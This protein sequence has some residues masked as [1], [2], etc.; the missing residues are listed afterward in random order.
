LVCIW[1]LIIPTGTFLLHLLTLRFVV[2]DQWAPYIPGARPRVKKG[3]Q[4]GGNWRVSSSPYCFRLCGNF[5]FWHR[6]KE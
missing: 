6:F 5:V 4:D 2:H 3:S 1:R